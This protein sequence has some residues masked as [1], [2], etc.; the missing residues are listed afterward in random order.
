[1]ILPVDELWLWQEFRT[2]FTFVATFE[3]PVGRNEFT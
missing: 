3:G 2:R 1:M